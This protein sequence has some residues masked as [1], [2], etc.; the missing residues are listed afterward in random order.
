MDNEPKLNLDNLTPEQLAYHTQQLRTEL[1]ELGVGHVRLLNELSQLTLQMSVIH[2]TLS[3]FE[4]KRTGT[5][6][7]YAENILNRVWLR[8]SKEQH[9]SDSRCAGGQG[10][11]G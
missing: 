8:G 9:D 5:A 11:D 7:D 10:T 2:A 3:L 1:A 6:E 4:K